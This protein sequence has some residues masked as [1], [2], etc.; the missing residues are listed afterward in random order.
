MCKCKDGD[1]DEGEVEDEVAGEDMGEG[2][3]R[4]RVEVT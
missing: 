1:R 2:E 4:A 3:M